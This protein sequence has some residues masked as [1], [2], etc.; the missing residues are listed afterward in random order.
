MN[1]LS[2]YVTRPWRRRTS[3]TTGNDANTFDD[4]DVGDG[5]W[6]QNVTNFTSRF[7][8]ILAEFIHH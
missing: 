7:S 2:I 8:R 6:R 3:V 4:I 1:C 5:S